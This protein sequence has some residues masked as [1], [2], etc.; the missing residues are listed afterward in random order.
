M[1][2]EE[3]ILEAFKA[4]NEESSIIDNQL[5][6]MDFHLAENMPWALF[7]KIDA[8]SKKLQAIYK[9]YVLG[10]IEDDKKARI[11]IMK[12]VKEAITNLPQNLNGF[13]SFWK[14]HSDCNDQG[15]KNHK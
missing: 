14:E 7:Q 6:R 15:C 10:V 2:K 3:I 1:T 5:K 9:S 8:E 12:S 11:Q 13:R 4:C